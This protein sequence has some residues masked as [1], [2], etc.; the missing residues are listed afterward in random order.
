MNCPNCG[1]AINENDRFCGYC[2]V[3]VQSAGAQP[4]DSSQP[5]YQQPAVGLQAEPLYQQP[6]AG[7]QSQQQS[8]AGFQP[9]P[10][11]AF[12]QA[13]YQQPSPQ[14]FPQPGF[15]IAGK[16]AAALNPGAAKN[17]A[18]LLLVLAAL[19]FVLSF[20]LPM[21]NNTVIVY[22]VG[23]LPIILLNALSSPWVP[24]ALLLL[25]FT[26]SSFSKQLRSHGIAD[27]WLSGCSL[28]DIIAGISLLI[29]GLIS[30]VATYLTAYLLMERG[31]E[32]AQ[33]SFASSLIGNVG[34][35]IISAGSVAAVILYFISAAK[36][37]Q[38]VHGNDT[39]SVVSALVLIAYV[40][41]RLLLAFAIAPNLAGALV[42]SGI[43]T[44]VI[45]L[46]YTSISAIGGLLILVFYGLRAIFWISRPR[47]IVA[48]LSR[49]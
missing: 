15:Q 8:P 27:K 32:T 41:F 1:T 5:L 10:A 21:L 25:G 33:A 23:Y 2:G 7:L 9:Q 42:Q 47:K 35:F 3:F 13:M 44:S 37:R 36:S 45:G 17:I 39:L 28:A 34:L 16:A 19:G 46:V 30:S 49:Q 6:A 18:I 40:L 11:A 4:V 43:G 38:I 24:L 26:G 29:S 48:A 31:L 12:A 22:R 14:G 20:F